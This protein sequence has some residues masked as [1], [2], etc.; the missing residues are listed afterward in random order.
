MIM[1]KQENFNAET[2]QSLEKLNNQISELIQVQRKAIT[3]Y[4][5]INVNELS[6]LLGESPQTIYNRVHQKQIPYYKPGGKVLLFK[7][8]EIEEWIKSGRH[9]SIEEIRQNI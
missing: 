2:L 8:S 4:D 1:D 5:Y 7:I 6:K 3:G 9:S